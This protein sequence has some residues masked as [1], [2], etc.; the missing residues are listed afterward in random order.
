[1]LGRCKWLRFE[2]IV[3]TGLVCRSALGDD[4]FLTIGGG[5][6]PTGNQ[7]SLEKN[8]LYFQRLLS[9]LH[10]AS[11]PH[12]IFFSDGDDPGRDVEFADPSTPTPRV[13]L[14]LAQVLGSGRPDGLSVSARTRCREC[15]EHRRS[16]TLI[17]GS[18][19]SARG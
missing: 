7:V 15:A 13:N 8:V 11:C 14:L 2:L 4:H 16:R 1:M 12:E 6:S 3:L 19:K 5:Y 9:D 18:V 17:A 10:L